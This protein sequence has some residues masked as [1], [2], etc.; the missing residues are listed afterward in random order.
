MSQPLAR[1]RGTIIENSQAQS[2]SLARPFSAVGDAQRPRFTQSGGGVQHHGG[3][4]CE[5]AGRDPCAGCMSSVQVADSEET[6]GSPSV[7]ALLS[8]VGEA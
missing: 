7:F 5:T 1:V 6:Q 4:F 2:G 8:S 3:P